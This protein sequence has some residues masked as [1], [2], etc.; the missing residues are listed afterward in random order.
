[1]GRCLHSAEHLT[2][3]ELLIEEEPLHQRRGDGDRARRDACRLSVA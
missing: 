2:N 1:L 3:G